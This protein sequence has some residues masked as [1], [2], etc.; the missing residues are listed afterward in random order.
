[1]KKELESELEHLKSMQSMLSE[2]DYAKEYERLSQKVKYSKRGQSS[3][4][5]GANYERS[6]KK[7]FK[8]LLD[9]DLER[10]PLSGGFAKSKNLS[11]VKGDLNILDD[12]KDFRLHIECKDHKIWKIRDW[13]GQASEDCPS[14]KVPIVVMHQRQKNKG[15]KRVQE[16]DDFVLLRLEDFLNLVD[17]HKII[18][19]V[20]KDE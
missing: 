17:K 2:K 20:N 13:W 11:M 14:G 8:D 16:A 4:L 1:M 15:G 3:R 9:I 5:K 19:E 7:V 12:S 10:T 6:V 18:K